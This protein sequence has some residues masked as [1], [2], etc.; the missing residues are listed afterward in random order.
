MASGRK[1]EGCSAVESWVSC[2]PS[3]SRCRAAGA[4][5]RSKLLSVES[6]FACLA[7]GSL[8]PSAKATDFLHRLVLLEK[9]RD[10]MVRDCEH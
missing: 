8:L 7:L 5:H 6:G 2:T 3:S 4:I 9:F 1:Q 10:T